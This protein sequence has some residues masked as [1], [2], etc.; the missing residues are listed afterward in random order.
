LLPQLT[1]QG[2]HSDGAV[3]KNLS[4]IAVNS[5]VQDYE[6]VVMATVMSSTDEAFEELGYISYMPGMV[7]DSVVT[8]AY[9]DE[10][11]SVLKIELSAFDFNDPAAYG[12]PYGG[13]CNVADFTK[14]EFWGFGK[15]EVELD[16]VKDIVPIRKK[17]R[18]R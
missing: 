11:D 8:V 2:K 13:E 15:R 4:N 18:A 16:E 1:Y 17:Y 6:T 14:G 12:I 9:K 3:L 7:H 10:L 5:P